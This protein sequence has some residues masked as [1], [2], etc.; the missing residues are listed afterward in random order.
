MTLGRLPGR[1]GNTGITGFV[2]ALNS[3]VGSKTSDQVGRVI[4]LSNGNYLALSPNWDNGTVVD[5]GAVT[6]G[7]GTSGI[8]GVISISNS[9]VGSSAGDRVGYSGVATLSNSNYVVGSKYWGQWRRF[10]RGQLPGEMVASV[11]P[12][13]SQPSTAW[14]AAGLTTRLDE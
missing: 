14:L 13:L 4:A 1:C 11:L 7:N 6:W 8:T 12:G 2:S 5:A 10:R 3:L 9:L